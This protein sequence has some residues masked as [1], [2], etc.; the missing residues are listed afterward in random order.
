MMLDV[1]ISSLTGE[2]ILKKEKSRKLWIYVV[3]NGVES[4]VK[5]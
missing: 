2:E 4:L 3:T 5:K 1:V